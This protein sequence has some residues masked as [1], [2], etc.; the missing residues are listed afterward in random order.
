MIGHTV[1]LIPAQPD[2]SA[3]NSA[4]FHLRSSLQQLEASSQT[5]GIIDNEILT[6]SLLQ[7]RLKDWRDL[8]QC[9]TFV[10]EEYITR[11]ENSI[12]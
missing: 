5:M 11:T 9:T 2:R 8:N 1:E 6:E 12:S 3:M 4:F 7:R 10:E